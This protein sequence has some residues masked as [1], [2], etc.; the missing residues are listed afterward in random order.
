MAFSHRPGTDA[1]WLPVVGAVTPIVDQARVRFGADTEGAIYFDLSPVRMIASITAPVLTVFSTAD[2]LVPVDQVGAAF[3]RPFDPADFPEGFTQDLAGVLT[4]PEQRVRLLDV[5]DSDQ[6]EVF[7]EPV[8]AG[9][10]TLKVGDQNGG[11]AKTV[12]LPFSRTRRWSIVVIDEGVPEP[13]VGHF[14]YAVNGDFTAFRQ[15]ALGEGVRPDQ[16]TSG[17]LEGMMKRYL[18]LQP[19]ETAIV[20]EDGTRHE[21]N[22]LDFPEAERADVLRALRTFARD[23][24]AARR[25]AEAYAGLPAELKALGPALGDGSADAVRQALPA[26]NLLR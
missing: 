5:L 14:K 19:F 2:M 1:A 7:V 4:R 11:E 17:K 13:W 22:L 3:I 15:W 8:P 25:L 16:L 24:A 23:D 18:G 12:P 20:R 26:P 6:R 10:R 21:A 9:T